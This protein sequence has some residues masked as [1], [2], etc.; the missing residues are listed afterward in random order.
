[1]NNN[2]NKDNEWLRHLQSE[3]DYSLDDLLMGL[4]DEKGFTKFVQVI[5]HMFRRMKKE[6]KPRAVQ[7]SLPPRNVIRYISR[8]QKRAIRNA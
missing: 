2:L 8:T 6:E 5:K 1:M 3:G 4:E 7:R